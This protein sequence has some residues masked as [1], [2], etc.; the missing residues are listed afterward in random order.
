MPWCPSPRRGVRMGIRGARSRAPWLRGH[1]RVK[2][3]GE[4]PMEACSENTGRVMVSGLPPCLWSFRIHGL[5]YLPGAC[6]QGCVWCEKETCPRPR[7]ITLPWQMARTRG[8]TED[9]GCRKQAPFL[10][11]HLFHLLPHC[12]VPA[13]RAGLATFDTRQHGRRA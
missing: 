1:V 8:F 13:H 7:V 5:S 4:R 3:Q 12:P 11:G 2:A 9:R 6:A 10:L